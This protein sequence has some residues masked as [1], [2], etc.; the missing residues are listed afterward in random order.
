[1]FDGA[2]GPMSESL[3][4]SRPRTLLLAAALLA[5][6]AAGPAAAGPHR[7]VGRGVERDGET[8]TVDEPTGKVKVSVEP[9]WDVFTDD[10]SGLL[11]LSRRDEKG[12]T[13][14]VLDRRGRVRGTVTAPTGWLPVPTTDGVVLVPEAPHGPLRPHRLRFLGYDG[15]LRR[16][17]EEAAL[18]LDGF[19]PSPHG[20]FITVSAVGDGQD[21]VVIVY[22]AQGK[23]LWRQA[24]TSAVTPEAVLSANGRRLVVVE[25]TIDGNASV[26]VFAPDRRLHRHDVRGV[27]QLVADPTSAK[28]AAVGR[29]TVALLDAESGKLSWRR[30]EPL[31]LIPRGGV[32]FSRRATRLLVATAE[33]DREKKKARLSVRSYRLTDGDA[34]RADAVET[35]L[36]QTPT[37][38]DLEVLPGGERRVVLPDSAITTAPGTP[39]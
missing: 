28:V 5:L 4:V 3:P 11:I 38:V 25:R 12:H 35:P 8:L 13:V 6:V 15:K 39:E 29:D 17:V 21:W 24:A 18:V 33:R 2:G 31:D 9:G 20:R 32:R 34:E 36:G 10:D 23:R 19:R 14:R 16:E 37:I 26:S 1:M 7:H 30:N 22:D 27:S